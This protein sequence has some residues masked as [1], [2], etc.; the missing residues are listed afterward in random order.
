MRHH[1]G[2]FK[3]LNIR[4]DFSSVLLD[5]IQS[6]AYKLSEFDAFAQVN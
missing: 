4:F 6:D 1:I 3:G 5:M 2:Y